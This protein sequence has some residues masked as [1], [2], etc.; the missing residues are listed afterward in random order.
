MVWNHRLSPSTVHEQWHEIGIIHGQRDKT[1]SSTLFH[2]LCD[3]WNILIYIQ[4]QLQMCCH[5]NNRWLI[6]FLPL[7]VAYWSMESA[8]EATNT[9]TES[10][11]SKHQIRNS[12]A[13][14][15]MEREREAKKTQKK[16][17]K[18]FCVFLVRY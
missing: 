18:F 14:K 3:H 7:L 6:V 8:V 11:W 13:N 5:Y 9:C 17:T 10:K 1:L 15:T 4:V 2:F 16:N 12:R